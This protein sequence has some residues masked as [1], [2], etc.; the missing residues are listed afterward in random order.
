MIR[1]V[2]M[3][4]GV[5]QK[6]VERVWES[7]PDESFVCADI[8]ER[9]GVSK[10]TVARAMQTLVVLKKVERVYRQRV[11][12]LETNEVYDIDRSDRTR[13]ESLVKHLPSMFRKADNES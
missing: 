13:N 5:A 1:V 3:V 12:N 4:G 8:A 11:Y 9:L 2:G 6:T 7:L 10:T